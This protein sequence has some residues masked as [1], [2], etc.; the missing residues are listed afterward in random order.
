MTNPQAT[1]T[2]NDP[3]LDAFAKEVG[4]SGPISVQGERTRWE[5]G[6]ELDDDARVVHAP[7]GIVEYKPEEMT[8]TVRA[9]TT[10]ADLHAHLA[11]AGQRTALPERGGTVGGAVA[12]GENDFRSLGRGRV[13]ESL[14]QVR[15]ISAEGRIVTSGGPTVKNVSGFDLPRLICG[16]LGTLGLIGEVTLRTNPIPATSKWF[17]CSQVAHQ[18]VFDSLLAPSAVLTNGTDT[19]VQL[20]GHQIDVD[21]ET[22]VLAN[23]AD[24]HEVAGP[25]QF[26]QHR[27][28]VSPG[29][30][31]SLQ[32]EFI[33]VVGVGLAF[34]D[35]PQPSRSVTPVVADLSAKLKAQFDP[36]G[37]LNPGRK[38]A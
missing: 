8:I 6:G 30:I 12:V 3:I 31:N 35:Q 13:R 37:R 1:L 19:W 33:A 29:G 25:P 16:S 7:S 38:V 22:A 2:S 18:A 4:D 11:N 28:S 34:C 24:T 32:S 36:R 14:L 26:P 17:R 20:E 10:V 9:G 27:W 5:H 21:A 23:L 15:Y